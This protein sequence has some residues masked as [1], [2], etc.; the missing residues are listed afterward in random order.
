M[1]GG[2]AL[3]ANDSYY[4]Y[5][6]WN[7]K[8]IGLIDGHDTLSQELRKGEARVLAVHR[9]LNH[10]QFISTNRHIMQ[11]Y[12]DLV[13]KPVWNNKEMV[14]SGVSSLIGEEP[15]SLVIALNGY[16]VISISSDDCQCRIV[17]MENDNLVEIILQS[18]KNKDTE[19]RIEFIK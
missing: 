5:D 15:Y 3:N 13:E 7:N 8:Y 19:W 12:V 10:P 16:T 14:L 17:N 9:K 18:E 1:K 4:V 6:F 11:G 2:L